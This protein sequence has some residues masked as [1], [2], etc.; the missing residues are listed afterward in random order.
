MKKVKAILKPMIQGKIDMTF[1][2]AG[3]VVTILCENHYSFCDPNDPLYD[4]EFQ[5]G[6]VQ[7]WNKR[8]LEMLNQ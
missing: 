7:V 1:P 4:V 6:E 5:D 2:R 8:D 3:E